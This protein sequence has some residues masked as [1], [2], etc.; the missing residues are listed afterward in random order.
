MHMLY[1]L[2]NWNEYDTTTVV[3][4]DVSNASTVYYKYKYLPLY[5]LH[6]SVEFVQSSAL[7]YLRYIFFTFSRIV[8]LFFHIFFSNATLDIVTF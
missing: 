5:L 2:I 4:L 6:A 8:I 3:A 7:R 1:I